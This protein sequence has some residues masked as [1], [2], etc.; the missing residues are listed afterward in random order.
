MLNNISRMSPETL[1]L[2]VLNEG[3]ILITSK[4]GEY[5]MHKNRDIESDV[6]VLSAG[7]GLSFIL[8]GKNRE[9]KYEIADFFILNG[10]GVNGVNHSGGYDITPLHGAV[11]ENDM[12][13]VVFLLNRG[14]SKSIKAPTINMDPLELAQSLQIKEPMIDRRKIIEILID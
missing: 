14:A 8:E 7:A 5:Y 12:D 13:M 11:L 3:G 6:K 9:K 1:I 2:C 4:L 10:L